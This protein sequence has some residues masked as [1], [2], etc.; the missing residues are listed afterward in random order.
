MVDIVA[1]SSKW[2]IQLTSIFTPHK[3]RFEVQVVIYRL[4]SYY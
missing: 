1:M 4:E 2:F 3:Q